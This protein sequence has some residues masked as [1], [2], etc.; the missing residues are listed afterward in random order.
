MTSRPYLAG[1]ALKTQEAA[2]PRP[3]VAILRAA[4]L[5]EMQEGGNPRFENS[6]LCRVLLNTLLNLM[7]HQTLPK[8]IDSFALY[9]R[10]CDALDALSKEQPS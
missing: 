9:G 1:L 6:P 5:T 2:N 8:Y 10:D 4:I 7:G 3:V